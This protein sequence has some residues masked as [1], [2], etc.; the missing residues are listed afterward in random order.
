MFGFS[1]WT[2]CLR[3]HVQCRKPVPFLTF[4][5]IL[6]PYCLFLVSHPN[7]FLLPVNS[8]SQRIFLLIPPATALGQNL[9]SSP[10]SYCSSLWLLPLHQILYVYKPSSKASPVLAFQTQTL[11]ILCFCFMMPHHLLCVAQTH[12]FLTYL[13][14]SQG[15]ESFS[16]T[17]LG[18][19]QLAYCSH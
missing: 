5:L 19:F 14:F 16:L 15:Q 7:L 11:N 1:T 6:T 13:Q 4:L 8:L 9:T 12:F 2:S 3:L 18:L 10:L 17:H